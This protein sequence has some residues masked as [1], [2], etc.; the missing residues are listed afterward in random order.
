MAS[1]TRPE[2]AGSGSARS[3]G[4]TCGHNLPR[5]APAITEPS[6]GDRRSTI[7]GQ[8]RPQPVDLRPIRALDGDRGGGSVVDRRATFESLIVLSV[9]GERDQDNVADLSA[10]PWTG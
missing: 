10:W 3:C 5:H 2:T 1:K 6:A 4:S 8:R 9:Q 7:R